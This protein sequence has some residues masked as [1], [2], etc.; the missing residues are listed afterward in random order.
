[1][2]LETIARECESEKTRVAYHIARVKRDKYELVPPVPY[3][4]CDHILFNWLIDQLR[5]K[6]ES[7]L[8]R[9]L[10]EAIKQ[11]PIIF[12]DY[13]IMSGYHLNSTKDIPNWSLRAIQSLIA[14]VQE[15]RE[16]EFE[17]YGADF[18]RKA[19]QSNHIPS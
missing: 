4:L 8:K 15:A 6:H 10:K 3:E 18:D 16:T 7:I 13:L 12:R 11:E 1:M 19:K 2:T 9:P 5:V 14:H 17:K